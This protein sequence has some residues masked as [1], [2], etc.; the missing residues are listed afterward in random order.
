MPN[1]RHHF[2]SLFSAFNPSDGRS[3]L[4]RELPGEVRAFL[5]DHAF[6][7][8]SPH[9]RLS[10]SYARDTAI[11]DIKDVD[12]LLFIPDSHLER[13]PNSV[14]L[15][16]KRVLD[17]YPDAS[18]ETSG[19]RRSVH[20]EFPSHDLHLDIVPVV[21]P[22]GADAVVMVP[23]RPQERW[24][25]SDPLGYATRLSKL[26][27]KHG[28]KVKP[29]IKLVKAWR[30]VQMKT[31]RPKSYVL[32]VMVLTA[33]E[34]GAIELCDRSTAQNV[35]DFFAYVVAKYQG[36]MD[37]GSE[38]PRIADPQVGGAYITAGWSR[39]PFETFM[40]RAREA[41]RAC[42]R[43]LQAD[44]I[45]DAVAEW[46]ILFRD[47]WPDVEVVKAAVRAEATGVRP[48]TTLVGMTGLVIGPAAVRTVPTLPTSY[49][50]D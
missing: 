15:E 39:A 22:N 26:N 33:V 5:E 44:T 16:V 2:S 29:L 43:A 45:E 37:N 48:S 25:K 11:C 23:D 40:R 49:H 47:M 36:L 8:A 30:D 19:Q 32:E 3:N 1:M 7:T 24:I 27:Q 46:R 10:G 14:L 6:V 12:V 50:G 41:D 17:D 34:D 13:T 4:A 31:R 20:L 35:A 9:T 21:A 38:S 18:A 42:G 28:S